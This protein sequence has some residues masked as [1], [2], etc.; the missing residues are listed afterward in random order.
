M[1]RWLAPAIAVLAVVLATSA[2]A[3]PGKGKGPLE[4]HTATVPRADVA[5]LAHEGYDLVAVRPA[6]GRAEVDLVLS[7]REVGRASRS[8][9]RASAADDAEHLVALALHELGRAR[10]EVQAE[11]R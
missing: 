2:A 1:K 7:P 6:G 4:M 9:R 10:F 8:P 11:Q 5:K 3:A